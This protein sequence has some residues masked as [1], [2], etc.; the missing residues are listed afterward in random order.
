MLRE[1]PLALFLLIAPIPS[2]GEQVTVHHAEGLVHGFLALRA[3]D[4]TLLANGDLEQTSLGTRVTSRLAFRFKDGSLHE[5]T[6]VYSQRGR[7][8]LL[9]DHVVQ[10]GRS[11]PRSL[12]MTIDAVKGDVIVRYEDHGQAKTESEHFDLPADLANGLVL[13]VLKNADVARPPASL[14]YIAAT[15]KPRL[16][17]LEVSKIG[18]ERFAVGSASRKAM[19]YVLKPELGGVAGLVAPLV[20]KDPPVSHVWIL[21]GVAPAFVRSEQPLYDGGPLWRIELISPVWPKGGQ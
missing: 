2:F 8:R 12:D 20:G 6:V 19:H 3:L 15:P 9:S 17:K 13:T 14:G 21:G 10:K 16:I 4:G 5:E 18:E 7:F 11:F 1:L